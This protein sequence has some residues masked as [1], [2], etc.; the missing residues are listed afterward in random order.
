MISRPGLSSI[1]VIHDSQET[2]T[3]VEGK[4]Q[5]LMFDGKEVNDLHVL[6]QNITRLSW[7]TKIIA[8]FCLALACLAMAIVYF[9]KENYHDKLIF[10]ESHVTMSKEAYY[11]LKTQGIY[12]NKEDR[13][14]YSKN[15]VD[16]HALP[17]YMETRQSGLPSAGH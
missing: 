12:W 14:W 16:T 17:L 2:E 7:Q 15:N 4:I 9:T 3:Y 5:S 11:K 13:F 10:S 6:N 8:G 1:K